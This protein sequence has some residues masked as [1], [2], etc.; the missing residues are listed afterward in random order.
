ML[1]LG[2]AAHRT[3]AQEFDSSQDLSIGDS[4]YDTTP[5]VADDL[6]RDLS[7]GDDEYDTPLAPDPPVIR[8]S[9]PS[10][11]QMRFDGSE[12]VAP[13]AGN[14]PISR[15]NVIAAVAWGVAGALLYSFL[16]LF[17]EATT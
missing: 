9:F 1:L 17:V 14:W 7:A 6:D 15:G 13:P 8:P 2:V 4:E 11:G 5:S 10:S 3:S 12:V 16:W